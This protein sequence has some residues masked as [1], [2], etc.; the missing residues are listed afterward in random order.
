MRLC[1]GIARAELFL[2]RAAPGAPPPGRLRLR[3]V[4][5]LRLGRRLY[6]PGA[7]SRALRPVTLPTRATALRALPVL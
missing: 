4:Q 7:G 2:L 1:F 5:S 6:V 3:L